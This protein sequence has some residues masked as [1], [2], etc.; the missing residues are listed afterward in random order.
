MATP[1]LGNLWTALKAPNP[2]SGRPNTER[3]LCHGL[4]KFV[5]PL[6]GDA[7]LESVL[8]RRRGEKPNLLESLLEVP[9]S[10]ALA[11]DAFDDPDAHQ[12]E[13]DLKARTAR[14]YKVR[15][16]RTLSK[17]ASRSP[18]PALGEPASSSS[19]SAAPAPAAGAP[20]PSASAGKRRL[21]GE[22]PVAGFTRAE[23]QAM[24]PDAP[25]C[26]A[27]VEHTWHSR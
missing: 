13:E 8:D 22:V 23:V 21:P 17:A 16:E 15:K 27:H 14:A 2:E 24:L 6:L 18:Q 9:G 5:E 4:V 1:L 12:V 10:M 19:G 3:C 20:E 26:S 7:A 25:G 11:R